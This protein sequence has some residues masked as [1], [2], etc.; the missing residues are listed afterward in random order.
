MVE[1]AAAAERVIFLRMRFA[2]YQAL[3]E[4]L[5]D[6]ARA[7]MAYNAG[8]LELMSPSADH[9]RYNRL[10]EGLLRLLS[11]EWNIDIEST[12][13]VTLKREPHRGRAG[14]VVQLDLV[15][16]PPPDLVGEID[17]SRERIDKKAIYA[18]FNVAEFWRYDGRQLRA[19][20]LHAETY[21]ELAVS[22]QFSGL[23]IAE[24]DR[25]LEMRNSAGQSEIGRLWQAW[26]RDHRP[27]GCAQP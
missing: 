27:P 11:L 7:R 9:E 14:F 13:S 26:L 22:G 20:V 19:Y 25:L 18:A 1:V 6:D 21:V 2:A 23:P 12:G 16:G 4:E 15:D 24:L 17:I 8:A 3:L 10:L 5:G